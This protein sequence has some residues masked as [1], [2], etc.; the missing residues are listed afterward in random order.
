MILLPHH[1]PQWH[2]HTHWLSLQCKLHAEGA[3]GLVGVVHG[4][5]PVDSNFPFDT[6]EQS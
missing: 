5:L 6:W 4:K 1:L 2:L 3:I